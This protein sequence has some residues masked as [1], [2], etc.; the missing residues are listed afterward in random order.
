MFL[1]DH[2][3]FVSV[4]ST[5][6]L[7]SNSELGSVDTRHYTVFIQVEVCPTLHLYPDSMLSLVEARHDCLLMP[8][9]M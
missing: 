5:G 1:D 8:G 2:C 6:N 9:K 3:S 4:D 7:E